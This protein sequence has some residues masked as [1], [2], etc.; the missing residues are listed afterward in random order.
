MP[1]TEW[2]PS[3]K[4]WNDSAHRE[5]TAAYPGR[6][7]DRKVALCVWIL[8][9]DPNTALHEIERQAQGDSTIVAKEEGGQKIT[10]NHVRQ[11]RRILGLAAEAKRKPAAK[12]P[13]GL[14]K[15]ERA[16]LARF[17]E[18]TALIDAYAKQAAALAQAQEAF[19]KAKAALVAMPL[20]HAETLAEVDPK[21]AEILNAEGVLGRAAAADSDGAAERGEPGEPNT[22]VVWPGDDDRA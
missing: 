4:R 3:E 16:L 19:A 7:D 12:K 14:S 11:A 13:K 8:A 5:T 18:S 21:A 10:A 17:N 22:F 6:A 20:E 15:I 1:Q 2:V 9:S